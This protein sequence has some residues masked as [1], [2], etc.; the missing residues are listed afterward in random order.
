MFVNVAR[1]DF[2]VPLT[3]DN[4]LTKQ[5]YVELSKALSLKMQLDLN[6]YNG[7]R[8]IYKYTLIIPKHTVYAVDKKYQLCRLF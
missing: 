3:S 1:S 4:Y 5:L 8:P 6:N 7:T 2:F